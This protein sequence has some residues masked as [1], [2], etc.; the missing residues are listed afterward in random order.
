MDEKKPLLGENQNRKNPIILY[1]IIGVLLVLL[2]VFI[3]LYAT[4]T[5]DCQCEAPVPTSEPIHSDI[6]T[7]SPDE[8]EKT[9]YDPSHFIPIKE[10][11]YTDRIEGSN[12]LQGKLNHFDSPYFK[13]VDVYNME[14]NENRTILSNFKTY[15]QTS[16]YS[17]HCAAVVMALNYYDDEVSER[18]CM[19]SMGVVDPDTFKPSEEFYKSVNLKG[20]EEYLNSLNYTTTSNDDFTKE[21]FP[22]SNTLELSGWIKSILEKN[23]TILVN[24]ADW[25]GTTS[26]IIGIDNMG[27]KKEGLDHVLILADTY[28]TVDHLNDGYYILGLDK[29]YANWMYNKI[30]YLTGDMEKYATMR[31][32]VIHRKDSS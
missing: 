29:F 17:G 25:G 31:F 4:K 7:D 22:F 23:E 32:L 12:A 18:E 15:Q 30:Y 21:N 8:P 20:V 1:I 6:D 16:E 13:M 14:S 11:F 27:N 10:S 9:P 3:I 19:I 5:C 28:D 2:I 26:V 24:W